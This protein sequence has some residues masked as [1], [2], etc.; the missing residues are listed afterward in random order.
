M[1]SAVFDTAA[2]IRH[3]ESLVRHDE[4]ERALL[5]LDNVPAYYRENPLPELELLKRDILKAAWTTRLCVDTTS[6]ALLTSQQSYNCVKGLLRGALL[7]SEIANRNTAGE[8]PHLVDLGPGPYQMPFGLIAAERRFTY[9]DLGACFESRRQARETLK[10]I[11]REK[12][13]EGCSIIFLALEVIEHMHEP[14]DMAVEALRSC[15][16]YPDVV[17]LSTPYCTFHPIPLDQ[18][19][20]TWN[21]E[22]LRA[23]TPS[24]FQAE[25]AKVFPGYNW[26]SFMMEDKA[27]QPMSLVGRLKENTNGS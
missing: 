13:P 20:R 26:E 14:R 9:W 3:V 10:P 4:L 16:R 27:V 11:L 22:H 12:P 1:N 2:C 25:A 18:E 19:W 8:V 15:G 23:Y 7:D 21:I 24:E 17:M 6:D 5:V